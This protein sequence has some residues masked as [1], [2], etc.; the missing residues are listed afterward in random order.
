MS[1]SGTLQIGRSALAVTQSAIQTHG[2]NIAGA[3]DPN[4]SRQ[5]ARVGSTRD[6]SAGDGIFLGTGIELAGVERQVDEAL[7]R[8]LDAAAGDRAAATEKLSWLQQAE[9]T[10][11]ELTDA[12]LST[13]MTSFFNSWNALGTNPGDPALRRS[14]IS[15]G[16]ALAEE[17]NRLNDSISRL[18]KD[19]DTRVDAYA[20]ETDRLLGEVATLNLQISQAEGSGG[21][22]PSNALRDRRDGLV[23]ELAGIAGTRAIL[24]PDGSLN[25]Y[26][27]TEP[28][29][30]AGDASGIELDRR[31]DAESG[32]V[33]V[34]VTI[35]DGG[36]PAP[37]KGGQLGG[38]TE[39]Q[40]I[41]HATLDRIDAVAQALKHEVN[42][43]H[44]SGQGTRG[45]DSVSADV[46]VDDSTVPLDAA[47]AGVDVPVQNG[48]FV[49][50]LRDKVGGNTT[51]TIIDVPLDG[52]A[53]GM[54]LDDLAAQIDAV[55]GV[56]A[57]VSAGR[58]T[59]GADATS[60]EI[61]F[62]ED[63]SGVLSSLGMASFFTGKGA[64]DLAV[65]ATLKD[66]PSRLAASN[67][68]TPGGNG[69]ALAIAGLTDRT[70]DSLGGGTIAM[71]YDATLFEVSANV[72]S[73]RNEAESSGAIEETLRGQRDAIS[74]VSLD[75]EAVQLMRY[76]RS[77][78]AAARLV[79]ATDEM[80]RTLLELV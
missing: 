64:A 37:L 55:G 6:R 61:V 14:V 41:L 49:L 54:S 19:V 25:V 7:I 5:V 75:E 29:V 13:A 58:L 72:R 27:G 63:T 45:Y 21:G 34:T 35:S 48:S 15:E 44:A 56:S 3:S 46:R 53:G 67:D 18:A 51:S 71:A 11:N 23:H 1:L 60:Q 31:V 80:M 20:K 74:G 79:S 66:D 76:Q 32:R 73:A 36:G 30:I 65:S 57:S 26:A 12:D 52:T 38:A 24:Q 42:T 59:I 8:R 78:Q 4:Y 22:G 62:S 9:G 2:N 17:F 68:N 28:L 50:H 33:Q 43:I 40:S 69:A 77:Y 10:F 39:A 70:L 16:E 47:A